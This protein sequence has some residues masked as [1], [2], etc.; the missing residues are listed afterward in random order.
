[1]GI[2]SS[3]P[4]SSGSNRGVVLQRPVAQPV[5]AKRELQRSGELRFRVGGFSTAD[6]TKIN[7]LCQTMKETKGEALHVF[8][9]ER[10]SQQFRENKQPNSIFYYAAAQYY[11]FQNTQQ[12]DRRWTDALKESL[13]YI[14]RD[15]KNKIGNDVIA[16]LESVVRNHDGLNE[17]ARQALFFNRNYSLLERSIFISSCVSDL[18]RT[19]TRDQA[20]GYLEQFKRDCVGNGGPVKSHQEEK[21]DDRLNPIQPVG[22]SRDIGEVK[23]EP[24]QKSNFLRLPKDILRSAIPPYL[25]VGDVGRLNQV[26]TEVKELNCADGVIYFEPRNPDE[27]TIHDLN[28][29]CSRYSNLQVLDLKVCRELTDI[30]ALAKLTNLQRLVFSNCRQRTDISA[31]AKLTN[32]QR[33]GLSYCDEIS[34]LDQLIKLEELDLNWCTQLTDISPLAKLTILQR[35]DLKGCNQLTDI[36]SL[37]QLIKLEELDLSFCSQLTNDQIK[38]LKT[39]LPNLAIHR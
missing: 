28:Y 2:C 1:M 30:R 36:S 29:L 18:K 19:E 26:S 14:N 34:A 37:A 38:N 7:E 24:V 39:A 33:L 17:Q 32:L 25:T 21:N 15:F 9:T 13:R 27:F 16:S 5:E 4:V 6:V 8:L 22:H 12:P 23:S 31:L 20:M 10:F 35:L 11:A 3:K